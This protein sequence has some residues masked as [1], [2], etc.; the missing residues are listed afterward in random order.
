MHRSRFVEQ[1]EWAAFK[2]ALDRKNDS[3]G[4]YHLRGQTSTN[5]MAGNGKCELHGEVTMIVVC[6]SI[7]SLIVN[8]IEKG[9]SGANLIGNCS[10]LS[11]AQEKGLSRSRRFLL[12]SGLAPHDQTMHS[13]HFVLPGLQ[14]IMIPPCPGPETSLRL[15]EGNQ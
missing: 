15:E 4:M 11:C 9:G 2:Y 13:V 7:G 8:Y 6:K 10:K 1:V 3:A 14:A 5:G 12:G